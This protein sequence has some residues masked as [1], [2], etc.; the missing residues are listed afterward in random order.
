MLFKNYSTTIWYLGTIACFALFLLGTHVAHAADFVIQTGSY[1]GDGIDNRAITGL[2]FQ[3]D[4]V[5][6]KDD[7]NAGNAGILLKT[8]TMTGE[9]TLALAETDAGTTTAGNFIQSLDVDGFTVGTAADV[10]TANLVYYYIA[11]GGSDCTPTG[12]FC[13]GSYTGNGVARTITSVG[14]QP[15]FVGVRSLTNREGLW[16]SSSMTGTVSN[17]FSALAQLATQGITGLLSNGFSLGTNVGVN[18]NGTVYHFF[19]FKEIAGVFDVATYTGNATDNRNIT[20][21]SFEPDA[22][23]IKPVTAF[24]MVGNIRENYGDRSFFLSDATSAINHVQQLLST[25]GFQVGNST[26]VNT[27][28]TVHHYIAFGGAGIHNDDAS[29]TYAMAQGTYTGTGS[30]FTL[31]GVPFA[32]DLV[33]IKG[34]I[35]QYAVFRTRLMAGN[36][37][38]YMA[39]AASVFTNGILSLGTN[40]FSLGTSATVNGSGVTY[41]WTAFGNAARIDKAGG[42]SDFMIGRYVGTGNDNQNVRD[43]GIDPDLLFVKQQGTTTGAWRTSQQT[44]DQTLYLDARGQIADRIQNLFPGGFQKGASSE[45]NTSANIYDYFMFS[46]NDRFDIGQ[47]TGTGTTNDRTNLP[48]SPDLVWVKKITGG[49]AR[50]GVFRSSEINGDSGFP[51]LNAVFATTRF[52]QLLKNGF[53]LGTSV[54]TNEN[55]FN[56]QYV[57]WNNKILSQQAYRF[58]ENTDSSDVGPALATQD[59]PI[60]LSDNTVPLRMRMLMRVE[61]GSIPTGAGEYRLQYAEK[62][63]TCDTAFAGESYQDITTTSDIAYYNNTTPTHGAVLTPNTN[64]PTD[65][66][67]VIVHQSYNEDTD[68]LTS[69]NITRQGQSMQFDFA[70]SAQDAVANTSYCLRMVNYD[71]EL[72][73]DYAVIPEFTTTNNPQ[74]ISFTLSDNTIGFGTLTS[75]QTRYATGDT[76]GSSTETTAHTFT[77]ASNAV[78]GYAIQLSGTTLTCVSC[79]NGA[80]INP[81]GATP[82]APNIGTEQFGI[83]ATV[84]SGTGSIV[85][86]YNTSNYAFDISGMPQAITTGLGDTILSEYDVF[87]MNNIAEITDGGIYEGRITYTITASF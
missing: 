1:V 29:G 87:Y 57:A 18:T 61:G 38:A 48:F 82:T 13:V 34:N 12:T 45:T 51:F 36:Q 4:L 76:L 44:G 22:V 30:A 78:N 71:G 2:G 67:R 23:F 83:R 35:V 65:G 50:G 80:I 28:G 27:S 60:T 8:S 68:S 21:T 31:T 6:L 75:T 73:D 25:G 3:P 19:A 7:T 41:T 33:I 72:F 20:L 86:P 59:T 58:F 81:I 52:T 11:I 24:T 56:Y 79:S 26:S 15:D 54:E 17:Y 47:Y 10:N 53:R 85:S 32:P 70:L 37:T 43:L 40:G 49:T 63:G 42:A 9:Q 16:R 66:L 55:G 84:N 39:G 46:D 74:E 62:V 5:L 69:G 64:D 14:F 77:A